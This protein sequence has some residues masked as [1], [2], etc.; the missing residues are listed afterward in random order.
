[1]DKLGVQI[2]FFA[3]FFVVNSCFFA[4]AE[5]KEKVFEYN[6]GII[7]SEKIFKKTYEIKDKII[8][9]VSLCECVEVTLNKKG[10]ISLIDVKFDPREYKGLTIQ[11]IKLLNEKSQLTTLRLKA[12]I[13]KPNSENAQK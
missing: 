9:A 12:Y 11:E 7:S 4:Y 13:E 2:K 1:M 6:I 8:N 3:L 5:D 10:D